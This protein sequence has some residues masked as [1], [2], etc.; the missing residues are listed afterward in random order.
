MEL[1]P[2]LPY[3]TW[4]GTLDTVHRFAQVVGKIRLA[5]ST[6]RNHWWNVPFHVTGRGHHHP[7]HGWDPT[8]TIDFD[9][10][11]HRLWSTPPTGRTASFA[12][13]GQSVATF[14]AESA[15]P[16]RSGRR[17]LPIARPPVRPARRGPAVRR[18][19]RARRVRPGCGDAYWQVLAR[20]VV[21]EEFAGRFSGKTSPVHHFWHTFDIAVTRFSDVVVDQSA[22]GG[23]RDP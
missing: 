15:A 18:G 7:A 20:C 16:R 4:S 11:G 17:L 21:L 1:F 2:A 10:V 19:H 5:A 3:S 14:H 22:D 12:L 9:F 13:L 8:F 23:P 6:R